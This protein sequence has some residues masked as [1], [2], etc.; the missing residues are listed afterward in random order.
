MSGMPILCCCSLSMS[1]Q[2]STFIAMHRQHNGGHTG[3]KSG[4][5][6]QGWLTL[7]VA[8]VFFFVGWVYH[9]QT[10]SVP[11]VPK[12]SYVTMFSC[13]NHHDVQVHE[14][15][16]LVETPAVTPPPADQQQPTVAA[17]NH[18]GTA[19]QAILD[20]GLLRERPQ[21]PPGDVVAISDYL[22]QP[23]QQL[24]HYP[25]AYHWP[26]FLSE[27]HAQRLVKLAEGH[28]APSQLVLKDGDSEDNYKYVVLVVGTQD[29]VHRI[30]QGRAHIRGRLF[31]EGH[32][33]A[34]C[35]GGGQDCSAHWHPGGSRGGVW[36]W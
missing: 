18:F 5:R 35:A 17:P 36:W 6:G 8:V 1:C 33:P 23:T 7:V 28:M 3:T 15:R 27:E 13:G 11:S 29:H 32:R 4:A 34:I 2:P 16:T 14:P 26:A 30:E 20:A 9:P 10:P 31:H 19:E 24:S 12:V 22:V 21:L 25:R